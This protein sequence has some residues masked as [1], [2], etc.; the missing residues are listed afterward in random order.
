MRRVFAMLGRT[1]ILALIAAPLLAGCVAS[2][3]TPDGSTGVTVF[4]GAVNYQVGPPS[5]CRQ[6][7]AEFQRV[8]SSDRDTGNLNRSVYNKVAADLQ[9]ARDICNAGRNGE[10]NARLAAVKARYGYH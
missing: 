7:I 5:G 4:G 2:V 9:G 10:A 1:Q 8:I 6:A 3:G